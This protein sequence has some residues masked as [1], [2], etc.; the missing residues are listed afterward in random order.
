MEDIPCRITPHVLRHNYASILHDKGVDVVV[1][2][3]LLGH[4]NIAT[5]LDIYTHLDNEKR[6]D[7]FEEVRDIFQAI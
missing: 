3:D 2:K 5:T 7:R 4:A 6:D 1:A